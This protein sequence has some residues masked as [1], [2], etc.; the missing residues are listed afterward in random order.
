MTQ[1]QAMTNPELNRELAELMGW[2]EF[3]YD[4]YGGVWA[5]APDDRWTN[6]LPEYCTDAAASLEVQTAACD[7]DRVLYMINLAKV[8]GWN[9]GGIISLTEA[10]RLATATPRER[11]EAA[12][13][14]LSQ[15]SGE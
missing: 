3:K 11:A 15:V 12:Y 13:M 6:S 1:L 2:T 10:S 7:Q 9:A 14:T 5:V 8:Q 4:P